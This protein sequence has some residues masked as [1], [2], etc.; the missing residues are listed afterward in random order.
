MIGIDSDCIIDFLRGK[1]EA[2]NIV[3]KYKTE[4]VTTEI[5]V[6]EVFNGVF[7]NR[8]N[9][10]Q[11]TRDFF[12]SLD[13]LDSIGFGEEV[14]FVFCELIKNGNEIDQNDCLI[15]SILLLN[16]CDKIITRNVKDFSRIKNLK[17]INY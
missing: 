9:E 7:R 1:K 8:E 4:L 14:F 12:E 3:E 6:F 16:G 15:A 5:N 10:L 17:I 13:V 11:A 2:I